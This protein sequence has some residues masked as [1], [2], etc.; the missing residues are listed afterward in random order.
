MGQNVPVADLIDLFRIDGGV[1][2][3]RAV[4]A[5]NDAKGEEVAASPTDI[6]LTDAAWHT[7]SDR[8]LDRVPEADRRKEWGRLYAKVRILC[9]GDQIGATTYA[10]DI[11]RHPDGKRYEVWKVAD[12]D[13]QGGVWTADARLQEATT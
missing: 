6:P 13:R 5:T 9:A 3:E 2:I 12:Y 7:L 11:I 4:S 10:A 1:T 8:E